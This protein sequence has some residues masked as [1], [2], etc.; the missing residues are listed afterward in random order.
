[1][2]NAELEAIYNNPRLPANL[3]QIISDNIQK[4]ADA[5]P[6]KANFY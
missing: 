3:K 1:M 6:R 5:D 4:T 2:V